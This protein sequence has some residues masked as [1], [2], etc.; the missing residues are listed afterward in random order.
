METQ[1]PTHSWLARFIASTAILATAFV[2]LIITNF[3]QKGVWEYWRIAIPAVA[4]LTVILSLYTRKVTNKELL[5]TLYQEIL[6][7]IGLVIAVYLVSLYIRMGILGR[8]E[9]NLIILTLLSLTVFLAGVYTDSSF[10]ATGIFL[11][12]FT[13]ATA[14]FAQYLYSIL[15]PLACLGILGLYF[16]VRRK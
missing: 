3:A 7:W 11:G 9:A 4:I 16:I 12:G 14:F 6:H 5:T 10:L 2:G 15:I 13:A 1:P 8:F